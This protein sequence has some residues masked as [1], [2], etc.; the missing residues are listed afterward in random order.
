MC[1]TTT[2]E[3]RNRKKSATQG[4]QK[5]K[6]RQTINFFIFHCIHKM[7]MMVVKLSHRRDTKFSYWIHTG[8]F[9]EKCT[10]FCTLLWYTSSKRIYLKFIY[11]FKTRFAVL[12]YKLTLLAYFERK[13]N[14]LHCT[15]IKSSVKTADWWIYQIYNFIS[16]H[17]FIAKISLIWRCWLYEKIGYKLTLLAFY[18]KKPLLHT[19]IKSSSK[20]ADWW[21]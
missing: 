5:V 19:V 9:F 13:K 1:L 8:Q 16:T 18:E 2:K 15:V 6:V 7:V 10:V 20:T 17:L 11:C 12:G 21:R 4:S 3:R 14:T